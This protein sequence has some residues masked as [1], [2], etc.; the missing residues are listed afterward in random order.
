MTK[1][2]GSGHQGA[3]HQ[4]YSSCSPPRSS[5]SFPPHLPYLTHD[6]K[7]KGST[8]N[9]DIE[10]NLKMI[11]FWEYLQGINGKCKSAAV[12]K[13]VAT[14]IS[15]FLRYAMPE[16]T[17][18]KWETITDH[19]KPMDYLRKWSR[20]ATVVRKASCT[21]GLCQSHPEVHSVHDFL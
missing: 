3:T 13:A 8:R 17:S 18:P 21:S 19:R 5:Q 12:A 9:F 2:C 4:Y 20:R 1:R 7:K 6:P 10:A 11:S 14:D 16:A 15:K